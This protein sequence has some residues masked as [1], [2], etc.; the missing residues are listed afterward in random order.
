MMII[1][2]EICRSYIFKLYLFGYFFYILKFQDLFS[3]FLTNNAENG[4]SKIEFHVMVD[5]SAYTLDGIDNIKKTVAAIVE[6]LPDDICVIGYRPSLSFF[7][8]LCIKDV[9]VK[10]LLTIGEKDKDHLSQLKIDYF[11]VDFIMVYLNRPKGK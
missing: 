2:N 1:Y 7:V 4:Y 11:I 5:I 10:K 6:C 9:Y 3:L 8:A